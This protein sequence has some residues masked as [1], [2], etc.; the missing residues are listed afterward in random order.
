ML[1]RWIVYRRGLPNGTT[2]PND[3]VWKFGRTLRRMSVGIATAVQYSSLMLVLDDLSSQSNCWRRRLIVV[4]ATICA[5]VIIGGCASV[6]PVAAAPSTRPGDASRAINEGY[7]LLYDLMGNESNVSKIFI[8]KRVDDT[9]SNPV[10]EIAN[11]CVT[12]KK[13]LDEYR[14]QDPALRYDVPSLPEIEGRSRDLEGKTERNRLLSSS[15]K[16]FELRLIFTQSE[17]MNYADHLCRA[18]AE[19]EQE[20][21][22]K[23][24]LQHLAT[25][26][27]GFHE[28]MMKLLIVKP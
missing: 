14:K 26:C 27:S 8:I 9:V 13:E 17:A 24:F 11:A 12:A 15:G 16:E 19:K 6:H 10:K 7:S 21:A 5:G 4:A 20:P 18:L 23:A 1:I 3:N 25:Q 2:P 28:R 22:R